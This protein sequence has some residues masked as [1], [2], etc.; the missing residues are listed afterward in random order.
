MF[1]THLAA[2]GGRK[3]CSVFWPNFPSKS[4]KIWDFGKLIRN[5]LVSHHLRSEFFKLEIPA[6]FFVK[7]LPKSCPFPRNL[8]QKLPSGFE[9]G[10]ICPQNRVERSIRCLVKLRA[11][12]GG[13]DLIKVTGGILWYLINSTQRQSCTRPSIRYLERFGADLEPIWSDLDPLGGGGTPSPPPG[14]N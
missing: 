6:I 8:E 11:F 5:P 13:A 10:Q 1:R 9:K 12:W 14:F 4:S 2:E 3:F 7:F